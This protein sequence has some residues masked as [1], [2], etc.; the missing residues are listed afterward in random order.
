MSRHSPIPQ[1]S[2]HLILSLLL[3]VLTIFTS[4]ATH[5]QQNP[6]IG[7]PA[8]PFHL[9]DLAENSVELKDFQGKV[10]IVNFWATWCAPCREE[11]PSMNNAWAQLKDKDVAMLAINFGEPIDAIKAFV[12]DT[13]IDFTVLVDEMNDASTDWKVTAMPTTVVIDQKGNIVERIL[14]PREWHSPEMIEAVLSLLEE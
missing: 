12:K 7:Q 14:G 8:A 1:R 2:T 9:K 4:T 5:A 3:C 13:P 10:M 11:I 6:E